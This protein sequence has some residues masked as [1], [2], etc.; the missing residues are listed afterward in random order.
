MNVKTMECD[1]AKAQEVLRRSLLGAGFSG[2]SFDST[3]R[4]W[5]IRESSGVMDDLEAPQEIELIIEADWR[6]GD[7]AQWQA[8][9]SR[10]APAGAIEPEEPVQAYELAFMRWSDG[11]KIADVALTEA[12][13]CITT[14][15]GATIVVGSS[16]EEGGTAWYIGQRGVPEHEASWSVCCA[17]GA[18]YVRRPE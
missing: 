9:V 16:I 6:I 17:D 13:L 14:Q 2:F 11:S 1:I 3:F 15:G 4:L 7:K 12:E 18:L 8:K 10:L 5:F